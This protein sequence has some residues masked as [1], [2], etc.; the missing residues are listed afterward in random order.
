MN[1]IR[2]PWLALL[3]LLVAG[4]AQAQDKPNIL[5][6]WGDDIGQSNI[7]AYTFGLVGYTT[8]NIDRFANDGVVFETALASAPE[9]MPSHMSVFTGL[10]PSFHG[11]RR[12]RRLST[13][14]PYLPEILAAQGYDV[15]AVVTGAF[16]SQ[17]FGFERGFHTYRFFDDPIDD[18][19]DA[20]FGLDRAVMRLVGHLKS[21][22]G[23]AGML[24][25]IK[26]LDEKLIAPS[27]GGTDPN[28][29]ID[30]HR[31]PLYINKELR[32]WKAGPGRVRT[33]GVS[34]FGFG[35]TNASLIMRRVA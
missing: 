14:V 32:E 9:T 15:S 10:V 13:E 18:G 16:L 35:G 5:V 22:A 31:S 29:N 8:P 19:R 2:M 6:I 26:S 20:V 21:A 27:L 4:A 23:A 24:K 1:R 12:W 17:A 11:A 7:S 30:F 33:A 3:A 34:A 25:A 28:P